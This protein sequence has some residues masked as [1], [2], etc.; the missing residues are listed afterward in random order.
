M[1]TVRDL[2]CGLDSGYDFSNL[3]FVIFGGS[4]QRKGE[5]RKLQERLPTLKEIIQSMYLLKT[6]KS[7]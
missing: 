1:H 3:R 6:N 7:L 4:S 5:V 2:L